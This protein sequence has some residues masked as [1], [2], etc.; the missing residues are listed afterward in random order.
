[1]SAENDDER[2]LEH[3]GKLVRVTRSLV[4]SRE[5]A[6]DCASAAVLQLLERGSDGIDNT[7]AFLVTVAKRRA[8]DKTRFQA[9]ARLRDG[10]LAAQQPPGAADV[11]EDVTARAEARW[12]DEV[13]QQ[14]LSPKA[15]RLLRLLATGRDIGDVAAEM[16][17]T[18]RAAESLL[19]R[20]RRTVR[21]TWAKAL[22]VLGALLAG[23][24]R[25]A[26]TAPAATLAACLMLALAGPSRWAPT[27][28]AGPPGPSPDADTLVVDSSGAPAF[29]GL[30]PAV[31]GP[32]LTR[33]SRQDRPSHPAPTQTT[34]I[35]V[36]QPMGGRATL[37]RKER[38]GGSGDAADTVLRCLQDFTVSAQH[39]G[40]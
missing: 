33:M 20:A 24:R 4:D 15:Y 23:L 31:D 30:G 9:R 34:M 1:M 26:A 5:D 10:R 28:P 27:D 37:T 32:A 21:R 40:C 35:V 3:W 8:A 14:Q 25:T 7:Q 13:A 22:A 11:A 18:Q 17:M 6:E 38:E 29:A 2:L 12:V 36:P 16:E 39:I 19:L